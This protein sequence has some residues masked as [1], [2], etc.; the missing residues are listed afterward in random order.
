MVKR[1][2]IKDVA[3]YLG[4]SIAV[5][6]YVMSG[7]EGRV[8]PELEARIRAAAAELNYQPNQIASSLKRGRTSTLGLIVA[9]ISNPFFAHIA[10][11][12][13]DTAK[14]HGYTVVFGSSD[15]SVDKSQ[16]LIDTFLSRQVDGLIIA[17]SAG[18]EHQI[19][20][21]QKKKMP[22]VL[23]D[24]YFPGIRTDNIRIDNFRAGYDAAACL[25]KTGKRSIGL[26]SYRGGMEHIR[27]REEGYRQAL[28]DYGISWRESWE[29][30]ASYQRLDQEV[31]EGLQ[32]LLRP[33][34]AESVDAIFFTTNSL[35][36]QGLKVL[37]R[38]GCRI[39]D[40][41]GVVSFDES[42]AFDLFY[43]PITHVRQALTDMGTEAV[44]VLL[45]HMK[46]EKHKAEEI[47]VGAD[48]VSGGSCGVSRV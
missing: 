37:K 16:G 43:V 13:E 22:F 7:K 18:T 39:P 20:M 41:V 42:D 34:A 40:E 45:K 46:Q 27:Q 30:R 2:S 15:E 32:L 5:V 35:A 29:I 33:Q 38:I 1:T 48:L 25:L 8:S 4:V 6:S 3:K 12:I 23:I 26:V 36:I 17:P 21:L 31:E 14:H 24:R 47:V 10:R 19:K 28:T 44:R 11:I 9:D